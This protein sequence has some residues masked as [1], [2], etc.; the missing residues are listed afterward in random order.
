MKVLIWILC[1][2]A[3]ALIITLLKESGIRLGGI[4]T[5]IL[6]SAMLWLAGT[7]CKKWDKHKGRGNN[8]GKNG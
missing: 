3:N 5:M 7:L 6:F 2:F 1:I 8:G 4:P